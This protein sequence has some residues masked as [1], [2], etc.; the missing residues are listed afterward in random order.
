METIVD[1][2]SV[3]A[4][5]KKQVLLDNDND[6]DNDNNNNFTSIV[7]TSITCSR[8][9]TKLSLKL[10]LYSKTTFKNKN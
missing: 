9:F 7:L 6:N 1:N 8:R 2:S 10:Q 4:A 5:R 3:K